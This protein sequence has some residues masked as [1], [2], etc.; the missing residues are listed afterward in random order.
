MYSTNKISPLTGMAIAL[1]T[2]LL[3]DAM[4][5]MVSSRFWRSLIAGA[6]A[7]VLTLLVLAAKRIRKRRG[8]ARNASTAGG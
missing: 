7:G 8:K 5:D 6:T 4:Q 2:I 3:M 1:I